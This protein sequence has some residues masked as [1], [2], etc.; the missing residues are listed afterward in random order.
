MNLIQKEHI[1]KLVAMGDYCI[2]VDGH[3]N[4]AGRKSVVLKC[5][6]CGQIMACSHHVVN[7]SPLQLLPSIVGPHGLCTDHFFINQGVATK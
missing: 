2:C 6:F 1:S 3:P 5:P 7:E 4:N